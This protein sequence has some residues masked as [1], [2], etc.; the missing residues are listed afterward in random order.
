MESHSRFYIFCKSGVELKSTNGRIF[1]LALTYG[2]Q[3]APLNSGAYDMF[4]FK[5]FTLSSFF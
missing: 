3:K 2:H 5:F 1:F 4:G